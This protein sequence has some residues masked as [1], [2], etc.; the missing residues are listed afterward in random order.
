MQF[1]KHVGAQILPYSGYAATE[2]YAAASRSN[3]RLLQSGS[4]VANGRSILRSARRPERRP[5]VMRQHEDRRV[6]RG[7]VA[8]PALPAVVRPRASDRTEHIAPKNPGTDSGKALLRKSVIDSRLSIVIA[9][10]IPPH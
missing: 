2:A 8:P 4:D 3:G 1:R 6:I 9:V 5:L 10:P 7:L